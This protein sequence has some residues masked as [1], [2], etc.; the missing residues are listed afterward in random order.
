MFFC[1]ECAKKKKWPI[2]WFKSYGRCEV[3]RE[4]DECSDVPSKYLPRP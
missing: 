2:G 1:D 3:C 4:V